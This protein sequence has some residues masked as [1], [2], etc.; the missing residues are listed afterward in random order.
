MKRLRAPRPT[1]EATVE[2]ELLAKPTSSRLGLEIYLSVLSIPTSEKWSEVEPFDLQA[3][4]GV[5]V[6]VCGCV[7]WD[8]LH[9]SSRDHVH[10]QDRFTEARVFC[11]DVVHI[12]YCTDE[13]RN[14]DLVQIKSKDAVAVSFDAGDNVNAESG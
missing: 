13:G 9:D 8:G 7:I 14:I 1:S 3:C 11:V 2:R 5:S 6:R 10:C 12:V 4:D